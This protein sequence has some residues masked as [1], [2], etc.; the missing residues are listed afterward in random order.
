MFFFKQVSSDYVTC[1]FSCCGKYIAA[2]TM[3]GEMSIWNV[4]TQNTLSGDTKGIENHQISSI[5]WN[6][7]N[8]GEIVFC[9]MTGQLGLIDNILKVVKDGPSSSSVKSKIQDEM[10]IYGVDCKILY[11]NNC[12]RVFEN[13]L[14]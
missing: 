8:N 5:S 6:P 4:Q 7:L 1:Q 3:L 9:D 14:T 2:G 10:D 11:L 13:G 12:N